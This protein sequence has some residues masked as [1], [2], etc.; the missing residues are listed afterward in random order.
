ML[1]C[2]SGEEGAPPSGGQGI[3]TMT[4]RLPDPEELR[5][6]KRSRAA[7]RWF[8]QWPV[9]RPSVRFSG[10]R[11]PWP[12]QLL[13]LLFPPHLLSIGSIGLGPLFEGTTRA[14]WMGGSPLPSCQASG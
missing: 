1:L 10:R 2:L 6:M 3:L 7:P 13:V 8:Q 14:E 9:G 12:V 5:R 11:L 4:S